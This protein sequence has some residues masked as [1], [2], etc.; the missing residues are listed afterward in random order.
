MKQNEFLKKLEKIFE[1]NKLTKNS[2]LS[3]LN[4][5][6]LKI[7]EILSFADNEFT[8]IKIDA[9]KLTNCKSINDLI[10]IFKI[11]D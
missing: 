10:K 8:D 2:S 7:L 1:K 11:K 3:N 6:S 9:N 5:D 4:F